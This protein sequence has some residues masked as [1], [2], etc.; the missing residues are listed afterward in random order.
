M[1]WI[2]VKSEKREVRRDVLADCGLWGWKRYLGLRGKG[3][4]VGET[5]SGQSKKVGVTMRESKKRMDTC[6]GKRRMSN[7]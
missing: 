2:R 5:W 1:V 4:K 6:K 7:S 3:E